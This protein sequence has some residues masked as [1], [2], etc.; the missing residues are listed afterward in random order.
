M[1]ALTL[2]HAVRMAHAPSGIAASCAKVVHAVHKDLV[3]RRAIRELRSLDDCML[4]D[5][6]VNR[7][8]IE[9]V[10]RGLDPLGTR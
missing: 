8:E 7:S 6:G 3:R 5:I 2:T 1:S 10:V 9:S 4:K